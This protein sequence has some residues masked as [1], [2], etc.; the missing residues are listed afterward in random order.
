MK[1][2]NEWT[3]EEGKQ[4]MSDILGIPID[5]VDQYIEADMLTAEEEIA[6]INAAQDKELAAKAR[7][8]KFD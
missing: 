4:V 2:F 6:R 5:E 8:N 3:R 1:P 7:T